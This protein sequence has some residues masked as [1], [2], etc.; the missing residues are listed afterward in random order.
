MPNSFIVIVGGA[1][2]DPGIKDFFDSYDLFVEHYNARKSSDLKK[3]TVPKNTVGVIITVDRSHMVFGNSNELTRYLKNNNI[4][5]VFSSGNFAS[6]NAAK[7]LIQKI[8]KQFPEL[9]RLDAPVSEKEQKLE[10]YKQE[11]QVSQVKVLKYIGEWFDILADWEK[12]YSEWQKILD[13]WKINLLEW[14]E[15]QKKEEFKNLKRKINKEFAY[16]IVWKEEIHDYGILIE[17]KLNI[18]REWKQSIEKSCNELITTQEKLKKEIDKITNLNDKTLRAGFRNWKTE[19]YLWVDFLDSWQ[20]EYNEWKAVHPELFEKV[21]EWQK[22]I[23]L[24]RSNKNRNVTS[25]G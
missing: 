17:S 24:W 11:W 25:D 15:I 6:F 9:I 21:T 16:L 1:S 13:E 8:H 22:A 4:P 12:K 23:E 20:K 14:K 2:V 5:F 19:F 3:Q 10:N 7:I 18:L